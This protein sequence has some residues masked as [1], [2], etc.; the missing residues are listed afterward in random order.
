MDEPVTETR[1]E[2]C[3]R[4]LQPAPPKSRKCPHCGDPLARKVNL[5]LILGMIGLAM[6]LLVAFFTIRL[7][8]SG[9]PAQPPSGDD[10]PGQEQ[11][12]P[13][14]TPAPALGQ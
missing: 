5:P 12:T 7:M 9:G 2:V 4:C 14:P 1:L 13:N 3:H 6:L 11:T 8:H 10:D